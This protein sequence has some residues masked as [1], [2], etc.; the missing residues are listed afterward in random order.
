MKWRLSLVGLAA[1][2]AMA[3]CGG[4]GDGPQPQVYVAGDSLNDVGV[5]GRRSTVQSADSSNP[6]KV[7]VDHVAANAGVTSL[8]AAYDG[9]AD[10]APKA[11]CTGY[12]VGG[13]QINPVTLQR[14]SGLVSGAAIDSD[15][16]PM[17]I[18]QQIKDMATGRAFEPHD[19]ILVDGGGNDANAL[20]S[21]LLEGLNPNNP[22]RAQAIAAYATILKDLLPA[23]TVDAAL[24]AA[25]TDPT[26][27][28][29]L[30]GEYM[31]ASATMLTNTIQTEL[32]AKGAE[33]VVVLNL[34]D[35]S[36]TPALNAQP[37]DAKA[38]V[39]AWSQALNAKIQTDLGTEPKVLIIDFFGTLNGWV[40]NPSSAR[41]GLVTLSNVTNRACGNASATAC[42]DSALD[43]SGPGDWRTHLFADNLHATPF[44][45][46]LTANHVQAQ[47]KAKG[48]N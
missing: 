29:P 41:L 43:A 13:A 22:L 31:Q 7:W 44:G 12:A 16:T 10:F 23:A 47:L 42:V 45:N 19:L 21:S 11:G 39:S 35:L 33:R 1:V 36:K 18:V 3:G 32:L 25:A 17:S 38:I 2:L 15:S 34:P 40:A 5:F 26:A 4:G 6:Y 8:C 24:A 46:Q 27:L 30:G 48:W 28:I 9:N 20:A 37:D 14:T